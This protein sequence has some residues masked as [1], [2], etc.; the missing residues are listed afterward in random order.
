MVEIRVCDQGKGIPKEQREHLFEPFGSSHTTISDSTRR[1]G[2]GLS[3]VR[4]IA[5][6]HGGNVE[7]LD[8]H[9][10]ACFRVFLPAGNGADYETLYSDCG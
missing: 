5:E 9:P 7:Y 2:L 4:S 8:N 6:V 3:L 10:G 1:M